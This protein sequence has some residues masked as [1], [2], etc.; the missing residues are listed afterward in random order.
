LTASGAG[1]VVVQL[2]LTDD[3]GLATA[4]DF[5]LNVTAASGGGTGGGGGGGGGGPMG[6]AWLAGLALAAALLALRPHRR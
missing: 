4:T 3:R 2:T 6:G 1:R 5:A